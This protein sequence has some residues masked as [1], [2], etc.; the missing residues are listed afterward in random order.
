VRQIASATSLSHAST[1]RAFVPLVVELL[2]LD[3]LDRARGAA[4]GARLGRARRVPD[5]RKPGDH[6]HRAFRRVGD[7]TTAGVAGD[8]AKAARQFTADRRA[9]L[10]RELGRDRLEGEQ[11]ERANVDTV[12][13]SRALLRRDDR[14]LLVVHVDRVEGAG[15]VAVAEAQTAP[16]TGS[17]PA[18]DHEGRAARVEALVVRDASDRGLASGAVQTGN[19]LLLERGIH[20]QEPGDVLDGVGSGDRALARDRDVRHQRLG[21]GVTTRLSA[22]TA[23]GSRQH[24]LDHLDAGILLHAEIAIR[25]CEHQAEERRDA[26]HDP[27]G[28]EDFVHCL[29]SQSSPS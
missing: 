19:A 17:T 3:P 13:A 7:A 5:H 27:A 22:R 24:A 26:Q 15:P 29:S 9:A 21:E 12:P 20:T 10:Y 18:V 16:G 14:K 1:A 2:F 8:P 28:D 23:V 4:E 11:V 6:L 25:G